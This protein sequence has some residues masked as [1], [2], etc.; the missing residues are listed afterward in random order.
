ME[1]KLPLLACL[2]MME[3]SKNV[4]GSLIYY[5]DGEYRQ[6]VFDTREEEGFE[7]NGYDWTSLALVF[8]EEKMPELSEAIDFDPEGSMFCAY[9]SKVDALAR[10]ALG[11]KEFCDDINTM[12][13]L[14][15]RA[16][17]D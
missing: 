2:Y 15:S 17:L 1:K 4:R 8:L 13:D 9:S 7:G 6:E 16:E 11:F 10:F 5:P 3:D 12:K 14:F